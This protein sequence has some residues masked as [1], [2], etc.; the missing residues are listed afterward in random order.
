MYSFLDTTTKFG[1]E[2][3]SVV[4]DESSL[5]DTS[6][7]T[8]VVACFPHNWDCQKIQFHNGAQSGKQHAHQVHI[9]RQPIAQN[10]FDRRRQNAVHLE[11][12]GWKGICK[13]DFVWGGWLPARR[14]GG[15]AS[16][17]ES[18]TS[19]RVHTKIGPVLSSGTFSPR[20]TTMSRP[21][22]IFSN[23]CP[24]RPAPTITPATTSPSLPAIAAP[25]C[26]LP[27]CTEEARTPET[28]EKG[29]FEDNVEGWKSNFEELWHLLVRMVEV[30][31]AC[32]WNLQ[33]W[34]RERESRAAM[35]AVPESVATLCS[36]NCSL[37][38]NNREKAWY[39]S[40]KIKGKDEM[41]VHKES[42]IPDAGNTFTSAGGWTLNGQ[43]LCCRNT[44]CAIL[45]IKECLV[46]V[47]KTSKNSSNSINSV[48]KLPWHGVCNFAYQ[49]RDVKFRRIGKAVQ[50]K[51]CPQV[52]FI[53]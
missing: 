2:S 21:P 28:L 4:R 41:D 49:G 25:N 35:A 9:N 33:K 48:W 42:E 26:E 46:D 50:K 23:A 43:L 13:T 11:N 10:Y 51:E 15:V 31:M 16:T 47:D 1:I 39:Q 34:V 40:R 7:P 14:D 52:G 45:C 20:R 12:R 22:P 37:S 18:R 36:T 30:G 53:R 24:T 44:H 32:W 29:S 19:F 17:T 3:G 38:A 6:N 27:T 8:N 5:T